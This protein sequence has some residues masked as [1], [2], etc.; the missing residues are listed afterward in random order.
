MQPEL[1]AILAHKVE[2]DTLIYRI[3]RPD[4]SCQWFPGASLDHFRT[5]HLVSQYW[6]TCDVCLK[7]AEVQTDPVVGF[8][9][10]GVMDSLV[11]PI[12]SYVEF[13][14]VQAP[15][16]R[17]GPPVEI[18]SISFENDSAIVRYGRD[19]E[20]VEMPLDELKAVAPLLVCEYCL[21]TSNST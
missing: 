11:S 21:S 14:Q 4:K 16:P 6:K 7:D 1:F 10:S 13:K 12:C 3:Q 9:L 5:R 8:D 20:D 18:V 15:R 2:N 17:L 19:R